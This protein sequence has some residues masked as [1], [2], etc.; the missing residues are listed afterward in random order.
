[1]VRPPF[2]ATLGLALLGCAA[3]VTS[4]VATAP[5][6]AAPDVAAPDAPRS[7]T[8]DLRVVLGPL[9]P[10]TARAGV[11]VVASDGSST[12]EATTDDRGVARFD[13]STDRRWDLT[14]AEPGYAAVSLLGVSAPAHLEVLLRSTSGRRPAEA[15]T[16]SLQ[17]VIRGRSSPRTAVVLE[18]A[19]GTTVARDD[20][21]S[22]TATTWPGAPPLRLVALEFDDATTFLNGWISPPIDLAVTQT[23]EV[24]LPS[25][26]AVPRVS[27]LHVDFP[28]V[29]RVTAE[30]FDRVLSE[31]VARLAYTVNGASLAPVG[32]SLFAPPSVNLARWSV[33]MYE[34]ALAPD[35]VS[36]VL[37]FDGASPLRAS[38]T[39]R[40]PF[41]GVVPAFAPV[42]VLSSRATPGGATLD[43]DTTAWSRAAFQVVVGGSVVWEGYGVD[44]AA[45]SAR[46]LPPLPS[47]V[48]VAALAPSAGRP[49][50]QACVLHDLPSGDAAWDSP[51][52]SITLR[53]L[54]TVCEERGAPLVG[55]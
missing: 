43:A 6:A 9:V 27:E 55:R 45:W 10:P 31:S 28:V 17:G 48:T 26:P 2:A 50:V 49:E 15:R 23:V 34:G 3:S 32:R 14:A 5:D 18:G 11:R 35:V 22:L 54:I 13:L 12:T 4:S 38:V 30:R 21:F 29:G 47:G 40:P 24:R 51:A 42:E 1:M 25:P 46:P 41:R 52:P 37:R 20:A 7:A 33:I 44:G 16:V 53:N 8:V 36:A 19:E 39:T